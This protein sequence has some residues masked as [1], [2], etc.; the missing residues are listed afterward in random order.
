[1][2]IYYISRGLYNHRW[3]LISHS[4]S[5]VAF[6]NRVFCTAIF[7]RMPWLLLLRRINIKSWWHHEMETFSALLA[8]C[9]GNSTV[10]GEFPAQRPVMRSFDVFFDPRLNKWLS[11][12][13]WD[14]SSE[15]PSRSLWRHC[16]GRSRLRTERP[17]SILRTHSCD[18]RVDIWNK[19]HYWSF[20]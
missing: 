1:M 19:I 8:L 2:C 14:W 4:P 16:N 20:L 17:R 5:K 11:K 10:I 7:H 12:Q 6:F 15:T 9:A 13:S 18:I 3:F